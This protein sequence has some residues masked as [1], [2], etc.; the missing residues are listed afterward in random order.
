MAQGL[1]FQPTM[2]AP[3][4]IRLLVDENVAGLARWFRFLGIDTLAIAAGTP[5]DEVI[6]HA[7]AESRILIT[8]DG[9]LARRMPADQAILLRTDR[10]VDQIQTVL[11][12]VGVTMPRSWFQ[13][14]TTCNV[15]LEDLTP[16]QLEHDARIPEFIKE[17]QDPEVHAGWSC[18]SCGRVFWKGSHYVRTRDFLQKLVNLNR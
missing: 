15:Q 9:E 6:R 11:E 7:Q 2:K 8:R 1:R 18:P 12:R 3:S 10:A 5:D 16:E 13:L 17:S 4:S 14:C